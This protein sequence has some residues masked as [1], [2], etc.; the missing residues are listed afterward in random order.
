[1]LRN[2]QMAVAREMEKEMG[3]EETEGMEIEI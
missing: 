1:M 2:I 3:E